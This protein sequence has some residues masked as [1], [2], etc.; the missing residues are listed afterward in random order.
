MKEV[1]KQSNRIEKRRSEMV[2]N[3]KPGL[4]NPLTASKT[5]ID[6][7]IKRQDE[8]KRSKAKQSEAKRRE[9]KH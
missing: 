4:V 2:R 7:E 6:L 8:A 1:E 3:A 9:T 5:R